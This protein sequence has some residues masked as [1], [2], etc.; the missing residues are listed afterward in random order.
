MA[1]GCPRATSGSALHARAIERTLQVPTL[2]TFFDTVDSGDYA[3]KDCRWGFEMMMYGWT[4][5]NSQD[6]PGVQG[7]YPYPLRPTSP[8]PVGLLTPNAWGLYDT[9]GNVSELALDPGYWTDERLS[10]RPAGPD[11]WD[12]G[13]HNTMVMGCAYHH[14]FDSCRYFIRDEQARAYRSGGFRVVRSIQPGEDVQFVEL[15]DGVDDSED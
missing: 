3:Y 5:C 12:I 8:R 10:R 6:E 13:V 11:P 14:D 7:T 9:T 2:R 15:L 4:Y 1:I